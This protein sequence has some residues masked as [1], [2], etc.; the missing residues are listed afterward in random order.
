MRISINGESREVPDGLTVPGL[1]DHIGMARDR[2]AIELNREILRK[3]HW[4][5]TR[6]QPNDFFEIV[7]F[8]GGG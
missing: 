7:N 2:V 1:L 5:E 3:P 6:V 4:E 8:V